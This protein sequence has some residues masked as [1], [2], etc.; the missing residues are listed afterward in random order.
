MLLGRW[1]PPKLFHHILGR[2]HGRKLLTKHQENHTISGYHSNKSGDP[3][4]I[5]TKINKILMFPG[6]IDTGFP[7]FSLAPVAFFRAQD[8]TKKVF[9]KMRLLRMLEPPRPSRNFTWQAGKS[10]KFWKGDDS[11]FKN[12][13]D[14]WVELC[15]LFQKQPEVSTLFCVGKLLWNHLFS[16]HSSISLESEDL[17][18]P[19]KP[20]LFQAYFQ[21]VALGEP[22]E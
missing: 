9:G 3:L 5:C 15:F 16:R 22:E 1:C 7:E 4:G 21:G 13:N 18:L 19:P 6:G 12:S 10:L 8:L 2:F 20:A 14:G 17:N 11:R